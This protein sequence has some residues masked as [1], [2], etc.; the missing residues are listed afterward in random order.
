MDEDLQTQPHLFM[1]KSI[2]ILSFSNIANDARVLRQIKYLYPLYDLTII[3]YGPPHS[4]YADISGINWIQLKQGNRPQIPNFITA[5]RNLDVRNFRIV[6]RAVRKTEQFRDKILSW[7]G[8]V[9]PRVREMLYW[10]ETHIQDMMKRVFSIQCHAY[11]ANDW[12]TLPIAAKAAIMNSAKLVIDLHEFAPLEYEELP[13]WWIKKRFIEYILKKYSKFAHASITV[14]APIAERYRKEY[15]FFPAVIMNAPERISLDAPTIDGKNIKL[16]HHGGASALRHPELMIETI[17]RC[18]TRYTLHFMFLPNKYVEVLK[19]LGRQLAPG[20]VFFHD[21]VPPDDIVRKISLFDVG[22][23]ILPPTN[24]NNLI[25]LPNKFLD[26]ICAGLAVAIGPSPSMDELVK[27]YEFG[28]VCN[29]FDPSDMASMLN[30]ITLERWEDMK[31]AARVA[32]QKI[33]A[34][35]EMQKLVSIYDD[36]MKSA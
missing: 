17:A 28:V 21:P 6:L 26:F 34:Q 4:S 20:R 10:R 36:L 33:N 18:D 14:A 29:S 12:N 11:H 23:Y 24:Y 25:A 9:I 1:R 27:K 35:V 15:N 13:G 16:F 30:Q 2:C 3:G 19:D 8:I 31:K 22:F 7:V 5:L 32:A